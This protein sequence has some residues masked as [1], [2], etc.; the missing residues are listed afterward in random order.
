MMH[1]DSNCSDGCYLE[2]LLTTLFDSGGSDLHIAPDHRPLFRIDGR[3]QASDAFPTN[4]SAEQVEAFANKLLGDD[5]LPATQDSGSVDGA[6]SLSED[7]RF[8]YNIYQRLPGFAIAIRRLESRFR[9]L[10]ELGLPASLL[11]WCDLSDGL[12]LVAGPTGS[13]K[14]TTLATF[15]D[16]IN[17]SRAA[18]I[19]TIEDPVEYLHISHKGR[20]DQRQIG[21]HAPDFQAALISSLRQDPDVILVGEIRE[22]ET[23]R[24]ALTAAE[25]GHLV[26]ATVHAPDCAG[27]IQRI[28]SVFPADEQTGILR[29]LSMNLRGVLTQH[30]VPSDGPAAVKPGRGM[31]KRPRVAISEV[32]QITPA[33]A[34][35]I[36]RGQFQNLYSFMET[37]SKY[38]MQTL[39]ECLL[40]WVRSGFL[41]RSTALACTRNP[42]VL[43]QRFERELSHSHVAS[44]NNGNRPHR[45]LKN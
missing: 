43:E 9:S 40:K 32:L 22:R 38:G 25:T 23:I 5:A 21:T 18:H 39:E 42:K 34:N 7:K 26:F 31:G 33:A 10:G 15:I 19:I 12:V 29:Q 27:A 1:T 28:S 2:E 37:G 3:L 4:I 16:H 11:N 8:R 30:L 17:R 45:R 14:S 41:Q 13:G 35:L 20:I 24:T 6:V 44:I 36:A